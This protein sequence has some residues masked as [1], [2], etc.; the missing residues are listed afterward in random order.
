MWGK[1][2]I[3]R[4]CL[5]IWIVL[6]FNYSSRADN[7]SLKE[8]WDL[9]KDSPMQGFQGVP[10]DLL[11]NKQIL[12]VSGLANEASQIIKFYYV[13]NMDE[14]NNG[15]GAESTYFGPSS[16]QGI[17]FNAKNIYHAVK[18]LYAKNNKPVVLFCHS[19][20]GAECLY[21]LLE[22][23]DLVLQGMVDRAVII[24]GAL[25]GSPLVSSGYAGYGLQF[26]AASFVLGDG[27]ETLD[28]SKV[29]LEFD[30]AFQ[31]FHRY[32]NNLW[33]ELSQ[34][35]LKAKVKNISD[36][37]FYVRSSATP[38]QYGFAT[39]MI[40]RVLWPVSPIQEESDGLLLVKDQMFSTFGKDLGVLNVDHMGLTLSGVFTNVS[41]SDRRAFTRAVLSQVYQP[42]VV[43]H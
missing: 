6:F 13:D 15:L 12:F 32:M 33:A 43:L 38:E 14:V 26:W 7:L 8:R 9:E 2:L 20:G 35:V 22:Y 37:V 24:Q 27:Y 42:E 34:D 16:F 41:S 29:S 1:G 10:P 28:P 4:F 40:L 17:S 39:R 31:R 23:P 3:G 25:R 11:T 5:L 19:K 36:R 30:K 21:T 18:E